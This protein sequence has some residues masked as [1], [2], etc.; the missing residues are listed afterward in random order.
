ME[1]VVYRFFIYVFNNYKEYRR[2][3]DDKEKLLSLAKTI[4][5]DY[6]EKENDL[7]IN[8]CEDY[9]YHFRY[10]SIVC[11][12]CHREELNDRNAC[13]KNP[14]A[15]CAVLEII[16]RDEENPDEVR[17][18]D[19]VVEPPGR[20]WLTLKN[21]IEKSA[22]KIFKRTYMLKKRICN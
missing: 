13:V 4:I 21:I 7:P 9:D 12:D 17:I 16:S 22:A 3:L 11:Y 18:I 6:Y 8:E 5:N 20:E 1:R 2:I 19:F 15:S 14:V 10:Y